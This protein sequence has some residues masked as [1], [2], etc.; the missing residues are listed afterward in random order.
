M[1]TRTSSLA[2][3]NNTDANF[4]LWINEVHNSLIAFGWVQATGVGTQIDFA[5]VTRPAG[6]NTYQGYAIYKMNDSLQSTCA[7]FLK[8]RFGTC[9]ST[10]AP[11]LMASVAIGGADSSGNLTGNVSVEFGAGSNAT[12]AGTTALQACRAAGSSSSFRLAFWTE[13]GSNGGSFIFSVERD[14]DTSGVEASTG[15]NFVYSWGNNAAEVH[16]SQFL[17]QAG[18]TGPNEARWYSMISGQSS[19]TAGG[20]VGV[21]PVRCIL[22]P[23]RN[24]M[25]SMIVYARTDF[26]MSGTGP[27]TIYGASHTYLFLRPHGTT[28]I[29][30]NTW[31]ANCGIAILWE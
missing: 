5:A 29:S 8:L 21:G 27:I 23:F 1:A 31:N 10:D 30:L 7:V 13:N 12:T 2:K 26:V 22:G 14:R 9:G 18:G 17:E 25:M 15:I 19:Q 3:D 16:N 20:L 11:S 24:P 6:T 4:R 28:D